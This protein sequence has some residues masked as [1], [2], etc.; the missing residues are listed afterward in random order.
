MTDAL[1]ATV[2][3]L[4]FGEN[5]G[6]AATEDVPAL[7]PCGGCVVRLSDDARALLAEAWSIAERYEPTM[8]RGGIARYDLR[9]GDTVTTTEA[10]CA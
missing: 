3:A 5:A 7:Y 4:L 9:G 10:P 1:Q 6:L 8:G 2:A